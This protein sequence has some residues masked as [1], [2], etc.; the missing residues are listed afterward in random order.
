METPL[1][2]AGYLM[3]FIDN[4]T[5]EDQYV[6]EMIEYGTVVYF[7]ERISDE[8]RKK[9]V[10]GYND[11]CHAYPE[12]QL[13]IRDLEHGLNQLY[14]IHDELHNADSTFSIEK[15][16]KFVQKFPVE[17]QQG[18][19][20]RISFGYQGKRP[21]VA[22]VLAEYIGRDPLLLHYMV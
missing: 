8:E 7:R 16:Q 22:A 2:K 19:I 18:L 10:T 14:T 21:G 20:E 11:S 1:R 17:R 9:L 12:Y 5:F 3:C 4:G 6:K 15:A 13:D